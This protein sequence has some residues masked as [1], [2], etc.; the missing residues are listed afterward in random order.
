MT[1]EERVS[2]LEAECKDLKK[3]LRSMENSLAYLQAAIRRNYTEAIGQTIYA[4][5]LSQVAFMGVRSRSSKDNT[6]EL[7]DQLILT[8]EIRQE[9]FRHN[10]EAIA[11][12]RSLL[13]IL[14]SKYA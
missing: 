9:N 11:F 1:A 12:A 13:E 3:S 7:L 14:R 2:T 6:A 5:V 4:S 8:L 10:P